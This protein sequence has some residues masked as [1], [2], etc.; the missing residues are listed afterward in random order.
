VALEKL[1]GGGGGGAPGSFE[2]IGQRADVLVRSAT[3]VVDAM[4]IT[5]QENTYGVIFSFTI[6][7]QEW[8]GL[9]TQG[10]AALYASWV[11]EIGGLPEVVGMTYSQDVNASGLLR[12]VIVISVATPDGRHE[13]DLSWPLSSL[14]SQGAFAAISAAYKTLTQTAALT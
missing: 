1:D 4:T 6:S 5:V 8:Q 13:T 2:V 9:G 7:R 11:Q 10:A 14:N 12:D 3:S